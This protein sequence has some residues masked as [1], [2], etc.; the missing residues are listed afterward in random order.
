MPWAQRGNSVSRPATV[1]IVWALAG[2][3]PVFQ[4]T[5]AGTD[6]APVIPHNLVAVDLGDDLHDAPINR[7]ALTAQLR[8]LLEQHLN[9]LA[10]TDHHGAS[11]CG[12][13]HDAI[14]AA[15]TDTPGHP[16]PARKIQSTHPPAISI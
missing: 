12:R 4:A 2:E 10:R 16:I 3:Q 15:T 7:V 1:E 8:Q 9:T 14:I 13:R 11:G 6:R 5:N